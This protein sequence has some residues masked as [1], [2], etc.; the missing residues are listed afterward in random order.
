MEKMFQ[1]FAINFFIIDF[2]RLQNLY[3]WNLN[4]FLNSK[5]SFFL[6]GIAFQELEVLTVIGKIQTINALLFLKII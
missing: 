1:Q 3:Q 4:R 2:L 5:K 6:I